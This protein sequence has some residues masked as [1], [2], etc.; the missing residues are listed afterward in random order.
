MDGL[1]RRCPGGRDNWGPGPPDTG[2]PSP[3][4]HNTPWLKDTRAGVSFLVDVHYGP[5]Q[6][7]GYRQG[8]DLGALFSRLAQGNG[9]GDHQAVQGGFCHPLHRRPGEHG[10]QQA[11]TLR[12]PCWMMTPAASLKVPPVSM[13]SS[14][15]TTSFPRTSPMRFMALAWPGA[16]R[17]LSINPRVAVRRLA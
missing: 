11:L 15:M 10:V 5:G 16:S 7:G 14:K 8:H 6:E 9:V 2:T 1:P 13:I 4:R 3:T 17:R 12:A